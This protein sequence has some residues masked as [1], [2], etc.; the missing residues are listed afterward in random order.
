MSR[1]TRE[2]P[3]NS[4]SHL[5]V[6]LSLITIIVNFVAYSRNT[7]SNN[8]ACILTVNNARPVITSANTDDNDKPEDKPEGNTEGNKSGIN[9][10]GI[11]L[12]L[13]YMIAGIYVFLHK[14]KNKLKLGGL[15]TKLTDNKIMKWLFIGI[16]ILSI[17]MGIVFL[18]IKHDNNK[19][20][21]V[22]ALF[23]IMLIVL[24]VYVFIYK[25][26]TFTD[27]NKY[28]K[29]G[30]I[31]LLVLT[32]FILPFILIKW[33]KN[34]NI[35]KET[36]DEKEKSEAFD[37]SRIDAQLSYTKDKEISK[38]GVLIINI[39]MIIV[40]LGFILFKN[41]RYNLAYT[42]VYSYVIMIICIPIFMVSAVYF[43]E[44][45]NSDVCN[46]MFNVETKKEINPNGTSA[47]MLNV[48]GMFIILAVYMSHYGFETNTFSFLEKI[49]V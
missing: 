21:G 1:L 36:D 30:L 41:N 19:L 34:T 16:I 18:S 28:V 37:N 8:K 5:I 7:C 42:S 10:Y 29:Y 3:E 46:V 9:N 35:E 32:R 27:T 48:V 4:I 12:I 38:S 44:C 14:Y 39:F 17:I 26:K 49:E 33:N 20:I 45:H 11:S 23:E 15:K 25:S 13:I 22:I 24:L 31:V 6:L 2:L 43:N 47:I 40:I